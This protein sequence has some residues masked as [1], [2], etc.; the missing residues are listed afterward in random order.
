[1][2]DLH[3][4]DETDFSEETTSCNEGFHSTIFNHFCLGLNRKKS[5][6]EWDPREINYR[7]SHSQIFFKKGVLEYFVNFTG[8]HLRLPESFLIKMQA[9]NFIKKRLQQSCFPV[10]FEEILR[11]SFLQN[12][13]GVCLWT[14]PWSLQINKF[15]D[16][17]RQWH[18]S[19]LTT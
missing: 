4:N 3:F 17:S 14:K 13:S 10:K 8:K 18:C 15:S 7:G 19:E 2:S 12:T 16:P 5:V 1:M 11:K 6:W 9:C